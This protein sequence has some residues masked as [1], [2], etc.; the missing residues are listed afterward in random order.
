VLGNDVDKM[1]VCCLGIFSVVG[2]VGFVEFNRSETFCVSYS[3]TSGPLWKKGTC[4]VQTGVL[5]APINGQRSLLHLS[6]VQACIGSGQHVKCHPQTN[7][8]GEWDAEN[9]DLLHPW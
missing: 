5:N 7:K 3:Q 4:K 2:T 1:P 8:F 6:H 9:E